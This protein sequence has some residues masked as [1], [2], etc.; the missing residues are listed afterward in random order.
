[1]PAAGGGVFAPPPML[2]AV[3]IGGQAAMPMQPAAMAPMTMM[4]VSP[5]QRGAQPM[6]MQQPQPQFMYRPQ[7]MQQMAPMQR[8]QQMP[9]MQQ[10]A[11]VVMMMAPQVAYA[12]PAAVAQPMSFL[13][14]GSGA[15][16]RASSRAGSRAGWW[17][18][19]HKPK[20]HHSHGGGHRNHNHHHHNLEAQQAK[21]REQIPYD[22]QMKAR[23][24]PIWD[25]IWQQPGMEPAFQFPAAKSVFWTYPG[26]PFD[27]IKRD[28]ATQ[29]GVAPKP[30]QESE[31]DRRPFARDEDDDMTY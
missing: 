29:V 1:M 26:A 20:H 9:Q 19:W 15:G 18:I 24:Y 10:P 30:K 11:Q 23:I 21:Y 8:M 14:T 7:P 5:Q 16:S 4:M 6:M 27:A 28:R 12:P 13:E 31:A 2:R 22:P 17:S 3:A 25:P